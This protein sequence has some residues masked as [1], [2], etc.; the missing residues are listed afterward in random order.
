MQNIVIHEAK[1]NDKAKIIGLSKQWEEEGITYG[2]V[3]C[4]QDILA[5][6]RIWIADHNNKPI[7][8]LFGKNEISEGM[9]VIPKG[10]SYFEIEDFYLLSEFRSKGIGT[11]FFKHIEAQLKIENIEYIL[12]STATKDYSKILKFY[13]EKIGLTVWTTTLFKQ[14]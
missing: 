5:S 14:L 4:S 10:T 12:L 13:T 6:Y 2:Y 11:M 1:D 8:F 7:G 3:A 9:C